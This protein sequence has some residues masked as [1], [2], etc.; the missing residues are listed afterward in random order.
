[1][2]FQNMKL[3]NRLSILLNL[4]LFSLITIIMIFLYFNISS[5]FSD[6]STEVINQ[7]Q[8]LTNSNMD[9]SDN[10]VDSTREQFEKF[11][12]KASDDLL[13]LT[14]VP[15]SKAFHTG[16]KRAVKVWLKRQGKVGGVEEVSVLNEHGVVEFSSHDKFLKR[17]VADDVINKLS[18]NKEKFR[19]WADNGLETYVPKM[20]ERK[21]LRCHVH[22]DWENRI[23]ETIGHFYIRVSTT[24][25]NALKEESKIFLSG[26][27]NSSRTKLL[28]LEGKNANAID[29]LNKSNIIFFGVSLLAVLASLGMLTHFLVRKL[30]AQPLGNVTEI[31]EDIAEGE[32]DLTA[33]I[34]IN[35]KDEIGKLAECFNTFT[36]K[37][38]RL[39]KDVAINA[40]DLNTSS[41]GLSSLSGEMQ[42]GANLMAHKSNEVAT[43]T[44]RINMNMTSMA[45]GMD[46]ASTNVNIVETS[47]EQMVAT[48]NEISQYTEKTLHISK[49]AVSQAETASI[50]VGELGSVA[51]EIGRVTETITE[52]SEQTNLLALNA[53]IEAA[54]AG[55]SG[56]GFAVV[57]NEIKE[58]AR[59]TAEA[60]E[61]I[62]GKIIGIQNSTAETETEI[63]EISKVINEVNETVSTTSAA[64]HEQSVT[65]NEIADRVSQASEGFREV[66][67]NLTDVSSSI[68]SIARD[69]SD[70]DNSTGEISNNSAQINMHTEELNGMSEKLSNVVALF[71]V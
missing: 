40:S 20:V 66:S 23:G 21:C 34:D 42:T 61:D 65:T 3:H 50:K 6:F 28:E 18:N 13:E 22:N 59:Q 31:F 2:I 36:D 8:E 53:T 63:Q 26:Q 64:I 11:Q 44:E 55:E 48:I 1:M 60:T 38:R 27:M 19:R 32:G 68:E 33:R 46:Q 70:V 51:Q 67:G 52:I 30:V 37:L 69:I 5:Q 25:L 12:I 49:Q 58:L 10:E 47:A 62:K 9:Q 57:A 71:K 14:S 41:S 24:V 7:I 16:D 35:R 29:K 17:K 54:R 4:G 45:E 43:A 15:F 56:K 39:I